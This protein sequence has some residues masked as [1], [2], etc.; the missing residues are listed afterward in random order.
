M[1]RTGGTASTVAPTLTFRPDIEGLRAVAVGL[2]VV[3]H[4][5]VT[6]VSGGFIGVD[7]FFV[8]SGFLITSLLIDEVRASQRVSILG[9]YARRARRILPAACFIIAATIIAAYLQLGPLVGKATAIDGRWATGFAANFHFIR[10]G[11]DYFA[12]GLA[13]SPLQHYWSLAVEEQFYFVWPTL[14][15][16][17]VIIGRR[18][19]AAT[20]TVQV[21][22]SALVATSLYW[23]IHQ[24]AVN[25]TTAYFSP[26]TRAWEL[27]VGALIATVPIAI[28]KTPGAARAV[29][30]WAGLALI[31]LSAFTLS[32]TT[33]FPGYAALLPVAGT[34]L[35][36][37]GG[38]GSP[39][40]SAGLLLGLP[41]LRWLGKISFSITLGPWRVHTTAQ[42][43]PP[44]PLSNAAR[45]ICV[46]ITLALSVA[47][48]YLIE[49]P[50]RRTHL[51]KTVNARTDW[52]Q[53]RRAI[54]A[55]ATAI[56]LA[57]AVSA[58]INNRAVLAINSGSRNA[59]ALASFND[60]LT[61][62][63]SAPDSSQSTTPGATTTVAPLTPAVAK[64]RFL[65]G[66]AAVVAAVDAAATLTKMPSN[67][68]PP[69]LQLNRQNPPQYS[70][71][72]AS[73]DQ[74]TVKVCNRPANGPSSRLMVLLGDSHVD[75]W[76]PAL[77]GVARARGFRIAE[78]SKGACPPVSGLD[79]T[80]SVTVPRLKSIPYPECRTWFAAALR[81]I[82][83][84]KPAVV[85]V[86]N[87]NYISHYSAD[88]TSHFEGGSAAWR[89]GL[90]ATFRQLTG[91]GAK[92]I[93]I[94]GT[95]IIKGNGATCLTRSGNNP[96]PC[97]FSPQYV[98]EQRDVEAPAAA[99][100]GAHYIDVAPWFCTNS[101]C[102][103]SID[104][105]V[106]L[107]DSNHL[108]VEYAVDLSDMLGRAFDDALTS[109]P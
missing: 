93:M 2:V 56:M 100:A 24:S 28:A 14:L 43:R 51:L 16:G 106:V 79:V 104:N 6:S 86:S 52:Q 108:T 69:V 25:P 12:S 98:R 89:Q 65:D 71:C 80:R 95:P 22:L 8:V 77:D 105:R 27:G 84:L 48:Y 31:V 33:E 62:T 44:T 3:L 1:V 36:V 70:R 67:V 19:Q 49:D 90:E 81:T 53:S 37:A 4:A 30:S 29:A 61:T 97:G 40:R 64:Q 102:P 99:A 73:F 35:V 87:S 75:Q 82:V 76:F 20:V 7:V 5:G 103:F 58:Y 72:T 63:S 107:N 45:V 41:P 21:G 46:L 38:I 32:A 91:S 34:A 47:S 54:Y 88:A 85:V 9:F 96:I 18:L 11:T 50:V 42:Q 78:L 17:L 59:G 83:A 39:N 92:V 68:D 101:L 57:V 94:G 109:S 23:S 60:R 10:Q 15:F 74:T 26:L 55:G 13:P 66:Q